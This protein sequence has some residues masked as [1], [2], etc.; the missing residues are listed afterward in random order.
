MFSPKKNLPF[1][2]SFSNGLL[3]VTGGRF[4]K[5]GFKLN[6]YGIAK[7]PLDILQQGEILQQKLFGE[8]IVSLLAKS[9]PKKIKTNCCYFSLPD[10]VI[11]S[12]FLILP[13]VKE[14]EIQPTIF[15]KIK[16][17]LPQKFEEM[18]IDWQPLVNGDSFIQVNVVAVR[19]KIIDSYI[20]SLKMI[21]IFPLGFEPE[22]CSLIRLAALVSSDPSLVIYFSEGKVIFCF[23]EKGV[24]ILATTLNFSSTKI[25]NQSLVEKLDKSAKFWHTT[26]EGKKQI[27]NVFLAGLPENELIFKQA[28]KTNFGVDEVKKLPL[29]VILPSEFPQDRI[30]KLI[31][32]FGLAFSQIS[33]NL[34]TKKITL[35]PYQIKKKREVFNFK[36][37]I[38]DILKATS[39]ILCVF[40]AAY[41]FIFLSIFFQLE[42]RKSALFGWEKIIFTPSQVELLW[43]AKSLNQKLNIL[44]KIFEKKQLVSPV[45]L[46]FIEQVPAGIVVTDFSF[47]S[48]EKIIKINGIAS[49]RENILALEK[50]LSKLGQVSI[51]LS[52]FENID[53]PKFSAIIKLKSP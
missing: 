39:L 30:T 34:E 3:Q 12:K 53:K 42:K 18:Y 47:D 36:N 32:L 33:N 38:K 5:E 51:P 15:F 31:P 27:K 43:Q 35:I 16:D 19:K 9:Q 4:I 25:N 45:L 11:F 20:K 7:L 37:K 40:M 1:F 26:F 46:D 10:E 48:I 13:K 23:G 41:L 28:V 49:S 29:P 2:L 24:V 22:T 8:M 6:S 50:S 14:E 52:S 17:F 21:N 44:D